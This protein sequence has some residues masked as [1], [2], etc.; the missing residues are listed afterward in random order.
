[1]SAKKLAE[2]FSQLEDPRCSGKVEH[3]LIDILVIAPCATAGGSITPH[4]FSRCNALLPSIAAPPRDRGVIRRKRHQ[5]T[6]TIIGAPLPPMP[7]RRDS[8]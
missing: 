8:Q 3:L 1:M 6:L 4:R 5:P 7:R 2:H